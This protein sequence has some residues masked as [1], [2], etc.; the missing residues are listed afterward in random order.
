[1]IC[2]VRMEVQEDHNVARIHHNLVYKLDFFFQL[3]NE[4]MVDVGI[5]TKK[6]VVRDI[7]FHCT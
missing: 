2:T 1:M 4:N 7:C 3:T 6:D 5:S